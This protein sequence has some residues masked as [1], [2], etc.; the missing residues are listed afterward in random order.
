M[1]A[2]KK[3]NK[4]KDKYIDIIFFRGVSEKLAKKHVCIEHLSL[5]FPF[6]VTLNNANVRGYNAHVL[7]KFFF[8]A[9][10]RP[11]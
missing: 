10:R 2:L 1:V 8:F 9:F 7:S 11:K 6:N 4:K 3:Q 5:P